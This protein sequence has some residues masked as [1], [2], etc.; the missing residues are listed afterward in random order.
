MNNANA[1]FWKPKEYSTVQCL[2][3]PH[4]CVINEGR[5]GRCGVRFNNQGDL[6]ANSYGVVSG[7]ALDP[8]EKKPLGMFK[9]GKKILSIGSFGCNMHC[10]FCQ[11]N[12]ISMEYEKSLFAP[13]QPANSSEN[14]DIEI[15]STR[16]IKKMTPFEVVTLAKDTVVDGNVG[17]AYTYNEPL[18]GYEFVYECAKEIRRNNMLN[19]IVSNGFINPQPFKELL[20]Y[21]DAMNID[22]KSFSEEFYRKVGG[23]LEEVKEIIKLAASSLHLEITTLI[24]PDEND[25]DKEIDELASWIAKLSPDI[26][27]HLSRF[28]P[29]YKYHRKMATPLETM[30]R[31]ENIARRHL[32]NIYLGNV[33]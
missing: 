17:V 20:P 25:S 21:I 29:T 16:A 32:D 12:H 30:Y 2:L 31:L 11:N 33:R 13:C 9:S 1:K 19:V 28:F 4:Y 26:P 24:I 7:I 5:A 8:I 14:Y 27:L 23:G 6:Y 3:C 22:L 10:P 18:V 15:K